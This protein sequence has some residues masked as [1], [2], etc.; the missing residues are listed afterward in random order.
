MDQVLVLNGLNQVDTRGTGAS[1]AEKA[2]G[3]VACMDTPLGTA[4]A[5]AAEA[6]GDV[7]AYAASRLDVL[8]QSARAESTEAGRRADGLEADASS[9][10]RI[11]DHGS[12]DQLARAA[13][14]SRLQS[15][16]ALAQ[17]AAAAA[18]AQAVRIGDARRALMA[19]D[20]VVAAAWRSD[21]AEVQAGALMGLELGVD[22]TATPELVINAGSTAFVADVD[23]FSVAPEGIVSGQNGPARLTLLGMKAGRATLTYTLRSGGGQKTAEVAVLG[24]TPEQALKAGADLWQ[25]ISQAL[26][27]PV[28]RIDWQDASAIRANADAILRVLAT[29]RRASDSWGSDGA[30]FEAGQLFRIVAYIKQNP[31]VTTLRQAVL[32]VIPTAL[33]VP[34]LSRSGRECQIVRGTAYRPLYAFAQDYGTAIDVIVVSAAVLATVALAAAAVMSAGAAAGAA[35]LATLS[36]EVSTGVLTLAAA[37]ASLAAAGAGALANQMPRFAADPD[38]LVQALGGAVCAAVNDNALPRRARFVGKYRARASPAARAYRNNLTIA[39]AA[40]D[41]AVRA[42]FTRR[43]AAAKAE[44]QAALMEVLGLDDPSFF[45]PDENGRMAEARRLLNAGDQLVVAETAEKRRQLREQRIRVAAD[46]VRAG[47]G[48]GGGDAA[49]PTGGGGAIVAVGA[50]AAAF[51]LWRFLR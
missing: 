35:A 8:A 1:C 45:T 42:E 46:A 3:T 49:A 6:G 21:L 12:A 34:S 9:A 24:V 43:A 23:T 27:E 5:R 44:G 28:I 26:D 41:P 51:A 15:R 16:A 25:K 47:G 20:A 50:A 38:R 19:A 4:A 48:G 18:A 2:D 33:T 22:P 29:L 39:D 30:N 17:S 31:Q 40:T 7:G 10:H 32:G 14:A 37:A 13:E 11:G 36:I